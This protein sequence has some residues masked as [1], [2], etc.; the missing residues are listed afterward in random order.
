M[1]LKLGFQHYGT[2]MEFQNRVLKIFSPK[3]DEVN[4]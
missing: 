2:L 1:G 3:G 4:A